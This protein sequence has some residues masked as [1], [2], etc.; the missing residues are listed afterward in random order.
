MDNINNISNLDVV[1]HVEERHAQPLT[2]KEK[3][4]WKD[5]GTSRIAACG[6]V[7]LIRNSREAMIIDSE[8]TERFDGSVVRTTTLIT[9]HVVP[10]DDTASV[11][12]ISS[13][14]IVSHRVSIVSDSVEP[15]A[16][17]PTLESTAEEIIL[18]KENQILPLNQDKNFIEEANINQSG[19]FL[20]F[21]FF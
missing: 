14:D 18:L 5:G 17:V 4:I 1:E 11:S 10:A 8:P 19:C 2:D 15:V 7:D 21:N 9:Q 16:A 3:D 20:I 13:D 6:G 12:V